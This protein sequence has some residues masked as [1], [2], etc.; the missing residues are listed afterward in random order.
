MKL[1]KVKQNSTQ[2]T[3]A[4]L[5]TTAPTVKEKSTKS[6]AKKVQVSSSKFES[7]PAGQ[8]T[9]P[10][11]A[12]G[13]PRPEGTSSP[14]GIRL[15]AVTEKKASLLLMDAN[16]PDVANFANARG[17]N[18]PGFS[19]DVY[20]ADLVYTTDNWETTKTAK[21]QFM[22]NNV[23]KG[24]VLQDVPPGKNIEYA[25]HAFVAQTY[26]NHEYTADR[27]DLWLNNG[28]QNYKGNTTEPK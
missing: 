10:P 15:G 8:G 5:S 4:Q 16:H 23:D 28:G 19:V 12:Q 9:P 13:G 17:W 25:I 18:K 20:A 26:K 2:A 21:L 6:E 1:S 22:R 3:Q 7:V 24:F 11:A 14:M 27:G